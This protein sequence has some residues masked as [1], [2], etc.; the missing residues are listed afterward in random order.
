MLRQLAAE[1]PKQRLRAE[2][3]AAMDDRGGPDRIRIS[4]VRSERNR[5]LSGR[6]LQ[7]IAAM[8]SLPPE[9]TVMR[10]IVEEEA[11][12]SAVFFALSE[13]DLLRIL[14]SDTVAVGSDGSGLSALDTGAVVHPRSYGTFARVLGHY[15][16]DRDVLPLAKAVYKMSGLPACRLGLKDRGLLRAGFM[17][18]IVLFDAERIADTATFEKPHSYPRGVRLVM[19]NGKIAARDGRPTGERAGRVLRAS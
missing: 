13:E 12:V 14:K 4:S 15:V 5:T 7:Q 17:A 2:V 6:S 9:D 3:K 18:D 16:R 11:A 1:D 19:V 10:L 8:W